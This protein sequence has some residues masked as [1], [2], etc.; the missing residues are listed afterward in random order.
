MLNLSK[1]KLV[2][3]SYLGDTKELREFRLKTHIKQREILTEQFPNHPTISICS[4]Y[5][6]KERAEVKDFDTFHYKNPV[7]KRKKQSLI[8][9][10]LSK[11]ES[12][13]VIIFDDD[14]VFDSEN[15]FGL[16]PLSILSQ[17]L[18]NP[19]LMPAS[20]LFFSWKH[21]LQDAYTH[22]RS[23]K[24][25]TAPYRLAGCVIMCRSNFKVNITDQEFC[26]FEDGRHVCVDI[27]LRCKLASL[28]VS[29][30]KHNGIFYRTLPGAKDKSTIV[31]SRDERIPNLHRTYM[32]A[33]HNWPW[34]FDKSSSVNRVVPVWR[35]RGK[36]LQLLL[37]CGA[38]KRS[39]TGI[40]YPIPKILKQINSHKKAPSLVE[41]LK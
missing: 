9:R 18:D 13:A 37:D 4:G 1:Y 2:V 29:V 17:W 24:V 22:N 23:P 31:A 27:T 20:V 33:Y 26:N 35:A 3:Q 15:E 16:Q 39:K 21:S 7:P 6:A 25:V 5:S 12:S 11:L 8:L 38:L 34:L 36:R 28:G 41:L 10:L 14:S 32:N 30:G 19:Q 40:I